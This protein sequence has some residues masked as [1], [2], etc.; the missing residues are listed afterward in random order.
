MSAS[1][2]SFDYLFREGPLSPPLQAEEYL[3]PRSRRDDPLSSH[4]AEAE[5]K[6][7]GAMKGQ[8]TI[9]LELARQHPGKTSKQLAEFTTLDRYQIA[10]RMRELVKMG[11]LQVPESRPDYIR[12]QELQWWPV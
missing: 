8:Q 5:I 3:P 11:R 9:C 2:I 10:R 4:R 6:R 7:S 12:G 1:Q